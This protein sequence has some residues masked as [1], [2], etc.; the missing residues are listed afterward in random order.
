MLGIGAQNMKK[1]AIV[2]WSDTGNTEMMAT[3]VAE[4]IKEA[5]GEAEVI[6]ANSFDPSTCSDYD[7]IAFGC[8]AMGDE[9]LEEEVFEPMFSSA[10][11]SIS[12][13]NVALFGSY[14]WGDGQWMR[15]WIDRTLNAGA[16]VIGD[17]IVNLTPGDSELEKC[18]ELGKSLVN[19]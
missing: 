12:G 7:A 6:T 4:G 8:P 19:S 2:Y 18:R 1:I 10:E 16:K 5:G 17:L 3:G 13:K 15:D 11:K 9:V 14:D